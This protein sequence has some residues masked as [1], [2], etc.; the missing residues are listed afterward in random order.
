LQK[1]S[2]LHNRKVLRLKGY[3]YSS[4]GFYFMTICCQNR[5]HFLGKIEN[6]VMVLNDAGKM[7]EKWYFELEN[8]YPDKRC[9]AMVIMPNHMHC[10]IENVSNAHVTFQNEN[11][12]PNESIQRDTHETY[13]NKND[14][15]NDTCQR[16]AHAGTSLRGRPVDEN[17]GRPVD[18]NQCCKNNKI[19]NDENRGRPVD[20]NNDNQTPTS[21]YGMQNKIYGASISDVMDWF[22]TMTTNEYIRGVKQLGWKRF[23]KKFWQRSFNDKIVHTEYSL[24]RIRNYIINNPANWG[25]DKFFK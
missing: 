13:Q 21:K 6:G 15:L 1:K 14:N 8:K 7:V 12:I 4:V 16:D 24:E 17:R 3:D 5:E 9:H 18:E 23:N 25:K 19:D 10:I 2:G 11:V 22:K 20:E